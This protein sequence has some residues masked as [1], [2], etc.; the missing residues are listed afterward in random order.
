MIRRGRELR[1]LP[2]TAEAW[3]RGDVNGAKVD[4]LTS[5]RTDATEEALARD[6]KMLVEQAGSLRHDQFVRAAAYWK[7]LA[8]PEGTDDGG[9][10]RRDPARRVPGQQFRWHVVRKDDP[11]SHRR[12]RCFSRVGADRAPAVRGRLGRGPSTTWTGAAGGRPGPHPEPASGRRP[13]GD[14]HALEDVSRQRTQTLP[15]FTVLV[16]WET[17][18]GRICQLEDGTVLEPGS[19]LAGLHAADLERAV[20][21][22][23]CRVEVS[24]SNRLFSGATRR[25]I[26]VRDQECTHPYCDVPAPSCE[27]DHIQP[28]AAGGP[29]TQENGRLLCGLH[30]RMR[31]QRPPP[32]PR[33]RRRGPV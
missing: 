30:N 15:L 6:E 27:A 29:T 18:H 12:L 20:F 3:A 5:L 17:L 32:T 13:G 19:L 2:V 4:V 14:G 28:W 22:P 11:R 24:H 1:H 26:E 33:G 7:Q 9:E 21:T 10:K 8:D 16:G 23:G 25:A 31:H